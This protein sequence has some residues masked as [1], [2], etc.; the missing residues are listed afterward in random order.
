MSENEAFMAAIQ[1][2]FQMEEDKAREEEELE[3]IERGEDPD[4]DD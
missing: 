1:E 4:G 2:D 3:R